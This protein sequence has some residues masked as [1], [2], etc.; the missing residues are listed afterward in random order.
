MRYKT[1]EEFLNTL[2]KDMYKSDIVMHKANA[3]ETSEEKISRYIERL[4]KAHNMAKNNKHKMDVLKQFYYDKYVI[5][6]LPNSYIAF[7]QKMAREQGYGTIE[8]TSR[9]KEEMLKQVQDEQKLSLDS[10]I[11][12]LSSDDSMYPMWFKNYV[13]QGMIKLNKFDKTKGEFSKRSTETVEPF[14]ELNRESL[15]QVY[16]T[17]SNAI[18]DG[19]L[20]DNDIKALENGESFKK[21]YAYYFRQVNKINDDNE[22]AGIWIKYEQGSDYHSLWESLQGKN[23]GWCTAG[24]RTARSQLF[25]GDFYVYYTKDENNQFTNPRIA[26]RMEGKSIIGEVRGIEKNQNLEA[27]MI[28]IADKKLDEF[29]SKSKYIKITHDMKLLTLIDNKSKNNQELNKEELAFLYEIDGEIEG[30]GWQKDPRIE[31]IINKR[32]KKREDIAQIYNVNLEEVSLSCEEWWRNKKQTKVLYGNMNL[33]FISDSTDLYLPKIVIGNLDLGGLEKTDGLVLPETV[34][35]S[36]YLN[37]LKS[38]KN[39]IMPTMIKNQIYLE[40]VRDMANLRLPISKKNDVI[41]FLPIPDSCFM[42]DDVYLKYCQDK[43]MQLEC[44]QKTSEKLE[45]GKVSNIRVMEKL[46]SIKDSIKFGLY[47]LKNRDG[48]KKL[49]SYWR[50]N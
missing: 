26:I 22:T 4:E 43:A 46:V 33:R 39:V 11:E 29:P 41:S 44:S 31:E 16:T 2:Y 30:F 48:N 8:V 5:K 47:N 25:N 13:F 18:G 38:T 24:E 20:T 1:G 50:K 49:D 37:E 34:I 23:T 17:I 7:Q 19:K 32:G 15:A 9:M 14:I 12:Y 21:L 36:L 3:D 42:E 6:S 10:W 45:T 28:D 27:N 40:D 35:G